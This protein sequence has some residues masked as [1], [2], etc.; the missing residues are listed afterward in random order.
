MV[1]IT[2]EFLTKVFEGPF[3]NAPKWEKEMRV[4]I[5]GRGHQVKKIF[6]SIPRARS[7]QKFMVRIMWLL[8][9]R[10]NE[11]NICIRPSWV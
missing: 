1:T 4:Y 11:N 2:G 9:L 6:F 7:V 3:K 10:S 8:Y 5:E